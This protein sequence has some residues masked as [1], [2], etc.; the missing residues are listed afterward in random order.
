MPGQL[1][2]VDDDIASTTLLVG[3]LQRRG[4][5]VDSVTSGPAAIEWL[6]GHAC[7]VVLADLHLGG[8]SGATLCG[9]L[10]TRHPELLT[11]VIT[12]DVSLGGAVAAIRVGAYD[13]INKP[14]DVDSLVLAIER[15]IGHVNLGR[16]LRELRSAVAS[17]RPIAS[18]IGTSPAM[19]RVLEIV[20]K[21]ADSET[22]VLIVGESGTG[23]ELIARALHD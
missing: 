11:I 8:M 20:H 23:K 6:E 13:Y 4:Y 5:S 2:V 18:I 3:A 17:A 14:I 12:G 9:E 19:Q 16:E 21:V 1:L 15:A 7:D 10:H 22:S